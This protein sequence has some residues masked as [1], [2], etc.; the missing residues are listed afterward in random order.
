MILDKIFYKLFRSLENNLFRSLENRLFR[1]LENHKVIG[2]YLKKENLLKAR[3]VFLII[4]LITIVLTVFI[5]FLLKD[6]TKKLN[7]DAMSGYIDGETYY[8]MTY[9]KEYKEVSRITWYFNY[10]LSILMIVF[11]CLSGLGYTIFMLTC[12]MP[13]IEKE[14]IR[15]FNGY[16]D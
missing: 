3:K 16:K 12:V 5:I 9:D 7:G 11:V 10:T 8:I 13:F 15:M 6:Q 4:F 1:S 2:K 14:S